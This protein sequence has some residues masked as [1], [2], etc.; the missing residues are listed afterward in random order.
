MNQLQKA[1]AAD[2]RALAS[3]YRVRADALE[4]QA[5][6]IVEDGALDHLDSRIARNY[7]QGQA[8]ERCLALLD[9][10]WLTA[11]E[12]AQSMGTL[13]RDAAAL[14]SRLKSMGELVSRPCPGQSQQYTKAGSYDPLEA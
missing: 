6:L 14:L 8:V 3:R 1:S 12:V 11:A 10:H 4:A 5:V 7:R 13:R 2:L 9:G